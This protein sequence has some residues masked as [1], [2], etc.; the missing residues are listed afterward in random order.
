[1]LHTKKSRSVQPI[2]YRCDARLIRIAYMKLN[3]AQSS[4]P[5]IIGNF[6]GDDIQSILEDDRPG[7]LRWNNIKAGTIYIYLVSGQI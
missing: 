2:Y 4:P 6:A 5:Q 3:S 1:M 7:S